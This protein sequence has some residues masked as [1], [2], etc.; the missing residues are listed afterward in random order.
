VPDD[1]AVPDL[2]VGLVALDEILAA[3]GERQGQAMPGERARE[4]SRARSGRGIRGRRDE[5]AARDAIDRAPERERLVLGRYYFEGH[6]L[7]EIGE[8]LG[9]TESRVCQIHTKAI[10]QLRA[11]LADTEGDRVR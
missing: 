10:L 11:H 4:R 8:V 7:S 1:G 5:D 6:T 3:A 9:V 2:V